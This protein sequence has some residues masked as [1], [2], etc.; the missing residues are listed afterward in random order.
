MALPPFAVISLT[1]VSIRASSLL[2]ARLS[3]LY[4]TDDVR[5]YDLTGASKSVLTETERHSASSDATKAF[6]ASMAAT[7]SL[8]NGRRR[9]ASG[10]PARSTIAAASLIGSPGWLW[11]TLFALSRV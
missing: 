1:R 8:P 4:R 11:F 5:R 9:G 6:L 10:F 7:V 2:R 3:L